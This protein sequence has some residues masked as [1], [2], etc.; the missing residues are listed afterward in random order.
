MAIAHA[1]AASLANDKMTEQC[2]KAKGR[3]ITRLLYSA[4]TAMEA[5]SGISRDIFGGAHDMPGRLDPLVVLDRLETDPVVAAG[6]EIAAILK[7]YDKL[8][9][10][11]LH[12]GPREKGQIRRDQRALY[13]RRWALQELIACSRAMTP[14]AAL[15]QV[16]VAHDRVGIME[17][18]DDEVA[19]ARECP[20]LSK[21][22]FSIFELLERISGADRRDFEGQRDMGQALDSGRDTMTISVSGSADLRT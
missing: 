12:A 6:L 5:A 10:A 4:V 8:E 13:D 17:C 15:V 3:K 11:E 9:E 21:L 20:T 18:I 16:L 7:R 2:R 1:E 19:K 14:E 22:M